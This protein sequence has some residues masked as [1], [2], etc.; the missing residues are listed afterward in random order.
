VDPEFGPIASAAFGT[1]TLKAVD[2]KA[3]VTEV[4]WYHGEFGAEDVGVLMRSGDPK[5]RSRI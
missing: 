3:L 2:P 5:V 1:N 4:V